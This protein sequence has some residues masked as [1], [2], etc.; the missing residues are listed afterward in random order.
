MSSKRRRKLHRDPFEWK[1]D[2]FPDKRKGCIDL[3]NCEAETTAS[4]PTYLV[5]GCAF[6]EADGK[7][8]LVYVLMRCR[9][10]IPRKAISKT[11]RLDVCPSWAQRLKDLKMEG[12]K[13]G[14]C[15]GFRHESMLSR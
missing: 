13:G 3:S 4:A 5:R 14:P 6:A 15:Y 8:S 10:L 12:V 11:R 2:P 7:D 1:H 9:I